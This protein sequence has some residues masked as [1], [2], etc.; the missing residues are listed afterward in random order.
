M[1]AFMCVFI[2]VSCAAMLFPF[3]MLIRCEVVF[4]ARDQAIDACYAMRDY[5]VYENGPSWTEMEWD[6]RKW[7]FA[8]FYPELCK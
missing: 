4:S 8:Q 3:L 1:S 7:T 5:T 2:A 6:M